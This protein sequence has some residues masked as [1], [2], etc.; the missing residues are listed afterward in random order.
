MRLCLLTLSLYLVSCAHVPIHPGTQHVTPC[1]IQVR[2]GH[3]DHRLDEAE[4]LSLEAIAPALLTTPAEACAALGGW[5]LIIRQDVN[6]N[7]SYYHEGLGF[8][9]FGVTDK[10]RHTIEIGRDS[11]LRSTTLAHELVHALEHEGFGG[12]DR[13]KCSAAEVQAVGYPEGQARHH[14]SWARRGIWDAISSVPLPN[15]GT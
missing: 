12:A 2:D 10:F 3:A 7:G 15:D 13:Y 4:A 9:V 11:W 6:E 1:G 5:V 8:R 14:C